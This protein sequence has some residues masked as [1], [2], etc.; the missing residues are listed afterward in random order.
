[1]K[2]HSTQEGRAS[3]TSTADLTKFQDLIGQNPTPDRVC[4]ELARLLRVRTSEVA[5]LQLEKGMLRFLFPPGLRAAGTIPV[6]GSAVAARTAATV[7]GV[8]ANNFAKVKH[9]RVFE[10]VR[11]G[12]GEQGEDLDATPI[13]KIMSVPVQADGEV[14][15]VIQISRKGLD[16]VS[17]GPDFTTDDLRLLEKAAAAIAKM[18]VLSE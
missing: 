7:T 13:Q 5:L 4:A 3:S 14:L 2:K 16:A 17:S 12:T 11:S 6:S 9:V 18:K 15:G 8:L 10:D 1:M